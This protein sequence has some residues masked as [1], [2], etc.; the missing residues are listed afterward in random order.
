[1]K[2]SST[3]PKCDSSKIACV[4]MPKNSGNYIS[5]GWSKI[6]LDRWVCTA[7]GHVETWVRNHA[8]LAR[9]DAAKL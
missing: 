8:D 6:A 1:M 3:C 4:P 9:I 2:N 7:C 5:V